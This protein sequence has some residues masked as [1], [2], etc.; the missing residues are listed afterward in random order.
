MYNSANSN[1]ISKK[2]NYLPG[3]YKLFDEG[4]VNAR[5]HVIRMMNK[6]PVTFINIAID[7][8]GVITMV[9]DGD[10]IDVAMHQN[11]MFIFQN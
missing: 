4:I 1:I 10:G 11:I 3:L 7:D 9:N 2:H 8:D 5:D 6:N